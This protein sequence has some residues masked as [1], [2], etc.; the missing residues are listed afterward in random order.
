MGIPLTWPEL[1]AHWAYQNQLD[2]EALVTR[3]VEAMARVEA[4]PF[5]GMRDEF[6]RVEGSIS[7]LVVMTGAA[8]SRPVLQAVAPFL[9]EAV[10]EAELEPPESVPRES[11][12][13]GRFASRPVGA[14]SLASHISIMRCSGVDPGLGASPDGRGRGLAVWALENGRKQLNE[15]DEERL[16]AALLALGEPDL[17]LAAGRWGVEPAFQPNAGF[18]VNYGGLILNLI[19]GVRAGARPQDISATWAEAV[20]HFPGKIASGTSDWSTLLWL[21]RVVHCVIGGRDL[22]AATDLLAQ[23]IGVCAS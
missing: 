11:S 9:A 12:G 2:I 6:A 18:H 22:E 8:A 17:A 20:G 16:A 23:D 7:R 5:G 15:F 10:A 4:R 19:A 1:K 13:V 3:T 14:L 21:A